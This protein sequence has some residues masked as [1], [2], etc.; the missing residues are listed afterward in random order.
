LPVTY[1]C[2]T[3]LAVWRVMQVT[4]LARGMDRVHFEA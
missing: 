2:G 1:V 3:L 4:G